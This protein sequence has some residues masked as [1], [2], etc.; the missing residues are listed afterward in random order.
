M[1]I[2]IM[3]NSSRASLGHQNACKHIDCNQQV[4]A[5]L[6]LQQQ[7]RNEATAIMVEVVY[8]FRYESAAAAAAAI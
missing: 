6:G 8:C 5:A 4:S 1:F 7:C 3:Y 2:S